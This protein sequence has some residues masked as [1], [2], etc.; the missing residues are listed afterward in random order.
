MLDAGLGLGSSAWA[1]AQAVP[2]IWL[3][4]ALV[5]G[6]LAVA[7]FYTG[8]IKAGL[9]FVLATC[10]CLWSGYLV[11][12]RDQARS[13]LAAVQARLAAAEDHVRVARQEL[14]TCRAGVAELERATKAA[15]AR[16]AARLR[17]AEARNAEREGRI[18]EL[19]A[20]LSAPTPEGGT[21]ATAIADF[22]RRALAD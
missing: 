1:L 17:E 2:W 21:C 12:G 13:E 15:A 5:C 4:S 7:A 18:A 11:A 6:G 9:M 10:F 3:G 14:A 22:R 20:K 8:A 16:V 19:E